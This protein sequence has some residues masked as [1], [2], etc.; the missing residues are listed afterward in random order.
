M[1]EEKYV[2]RKKK[3]IAAAIIA[4]VTAMGIGALCLVAFL[5]QYVGTFTVTLNAGKIELAMS[6]TKSFES[7]TSF[8]MINQLP[9]FH[10]YTYSEILRK[11][12]DIDNE[13]TLWYQ[14]AAGATYKGDDAEDPLNVDGLDFFKYTFYVKNVGTIPCGYQFR[15]NITENTLSTDHRSLADTL[16]VCLFSNEGNSNEHE[17]TVYAKRAAVNNGRTDGDQFDE[18]ISLAPEK[19]DAAHP[20]YGYATQFSGTNQSDIGAICSIKTDNFEPEEI[21]RYTIATWLEGNDLQANREISG[22][23]KKEGAPK[24]ASIKLGVEISAYE[25]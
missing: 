18:Y 10:E 24:G 16:R 9:V 20:F 12:A 22:T 5:G 2:A 3:K 4:G 25:F 17:H 11:A 7:P 6:T 15:I 8:L 14:K 19:C 13:E 23:G 21:R 1:Y